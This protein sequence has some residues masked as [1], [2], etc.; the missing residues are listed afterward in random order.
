MVILN[1]CNTAAMIKYTC[2]VS[3]VDSNTEEVLD[4]CEMSIEVP[5]SLEKHQQFACMVLLNSLEYDD[6]TCWSLKNMRQE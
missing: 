1:L 4:T 3:L 6:S 5:F 2:D